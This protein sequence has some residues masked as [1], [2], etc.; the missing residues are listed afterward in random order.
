MSAEK[1]C[2]TCGH[3]TYRNIKDCAF[4]CCSHPVTISKTAKPDRGDPLW[5]D[6][7]TADVRLSDLNFL[8]DCPTWEP[9]Q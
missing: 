7:M 5:V 2:R 9:R 1:D 6:F 4:V 8:E 3:N